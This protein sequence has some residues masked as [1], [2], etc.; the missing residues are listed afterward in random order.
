MVANAGTA[1]IAVTI[2]NARMCS[3]WL[4]NLSRFAIRKRAIQPRYLAAEG[5]P[6]FFGRPAQKLSCTDVIE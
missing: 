6:I 3:R 5:L 1:A 2:E 4:V